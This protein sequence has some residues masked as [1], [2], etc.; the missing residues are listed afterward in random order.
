M[1]E[2]TPVDS[3]VFSSCRMFNAAGR[4]ANPKLN[5]WAVGWSSDMFRCVAVTSGIILQP[6]ADT[7]G[8]DALQ[9]FHE[10]TLYVGL[11]IGIALSTVTGWHCTATCGRPHQRVA[12]PPD[13]LVWS[14]YS[15]PGL[16]REIIMKNDNRNYQTRL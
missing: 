6:K 9:T 15:R 3:M 12:T 10:R 11:S 13:G 7:A 14:P 5:L 8:H 4:L 2:R 16:Q 1:L